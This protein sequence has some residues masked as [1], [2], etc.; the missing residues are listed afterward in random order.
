M[1]NKVMM[2]LWRYV[3]N[4][5]EGLWKKQMGSAVRRFDRKLGKMP[6]DVRKVHRFAARTL[7]GHGRPLSAGAIARGL[8]M[9]EADVV[10]C[11]EYLETQ[12]TY[13]YRSRGREV[14][15]VYPVTVDET[16]HKVFFSTGE[17]LYAA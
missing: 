4:V 7:P 5:P 3:V 16:P 2:G 11:L 1:K 15:W 14:T 17:T 13:L 6:E 12:M 9:A 8:G 10:S